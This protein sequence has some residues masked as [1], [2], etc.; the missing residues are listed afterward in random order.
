MG[1]RTPRI[2]CEARLND[3]SR[4]PKA[5]S[6]SKPALR[7]L[8]PLVRPRVV[9]TMAARP[10]A[11]G[12]LACA[13]MRFA[14]RSPWATIRPE[15]VLQTSP[16]PGLAA[17]WFTRWC[18]TPQL[19]LSRWRSQAQARPRARIRS[20]APLAGEGSVPFAD[21]SASSL[22]VGRTLR[23]AAKLHSGHASSAASHCSAA[24]L[25]R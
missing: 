5:S 1:C 12:P 3:A 9:Q 15:Q 23:S 22:S 4:S 20:S 19:S 7:Q 13:A 16:M 2:S 11:F 24:P 25:V 21:P 10:Q 8:H 14:R 6:K 17:A 18:V